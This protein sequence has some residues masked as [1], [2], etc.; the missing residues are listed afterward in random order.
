MPVDE[1]QPINSGIGSN[2]HGDGNHQLLHLQPSG[3]GTKQL[4][5]LKAGALKYSCL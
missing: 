4:N 2:R 3:Y 1:N 5:I